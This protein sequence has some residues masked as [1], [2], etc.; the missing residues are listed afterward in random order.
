LYQK[1]KIVIKY[2]ILYCIIKKKDRMSKKTKDTII[3]VASKLF[4]R[5]GFY[6]TSMDEVAKVARKAK[7]SLY[8]HFV[9]KEGL[10]KEVVARELEFVKSELT[11][12]LSIT[13]IP[14]TQLMKIFLR[15]RMELL[16]NSFNYHEI[17]KADLHEHFSFLDDVRVDFAKWEKEQFKFIILKG[18]E[19]GLIDKN[20]NYDVAIDVFILILKSSEIQFF[21]QNRYDEFAPHF[22]EL[23]EIVIRG[24]KA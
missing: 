4:S 17:L 14:A 6:K 11:K 20:L 15:K 16:A 18:I 21:V 5:Y 3:Q 8:Y 10:F 22:D 23:I 2:I 13:N 1:T 12:I 7:G 9:N 24:I 19:E